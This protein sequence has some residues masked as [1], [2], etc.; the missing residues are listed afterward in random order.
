MGLCLRV[1]ALYFFYTMQLIRYEDYQVK[2]ADEAFL[3]KPI[4]KMFHQDRSERKERFFQQMS[5]LYFVYSPAS[6]FAYIVDEKERMREVQEQMGIDDFKPSP[7]FQAAVEIYKKVTTTPS[8][9]L[10][11]SALMAADTV[12]KFLEDPTILTQEDDKGKPKHSIASITTALKNVEGIVTSL[13]NLQKKV[14]QELAE[15]SGKARGTQELTL[16]DIGLD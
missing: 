12:S 2:I 8:Q 1:W 3:I 14:E 4:R 6:N 13:Q 9:R 5:M 16:G 10:L 7:D 15:E 11:K